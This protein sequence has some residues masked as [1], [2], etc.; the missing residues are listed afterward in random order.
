[1][2]E[3]WTVVHNLLWIV[4]LALSLAALSMAYYQ[5]GIGQVRL[6]HQLAELSFQLPFSIGMVLFCAGLLFSSHTSWEKIIWGL[7]GA[8]FAGQT[9]RQWGHRHNT[10]KGA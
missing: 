2:L 1:M 6:R 4:G 8:L 3:L 7:L 9:L 5:S 10:R